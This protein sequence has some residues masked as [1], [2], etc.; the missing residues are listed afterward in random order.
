M[1]RTAVAA[2][3]LA[4]AASTGTAFAQDTTDYRVL[5]TNKTSTMQK[6]MNEAADAGFRFGG[7]MGGE[8]SFGGSEVVIIMS[9]SAASG[10]YDYRLLAT[11]KTSTMQKEMQEAGDAGFEYKGQSIFKSA[12][13]GKEVVVILERDKDVK[14]AA[15]FEYRLL[16]TKKTSTLQ[17]ELAEAG[18]AGYQFV[19]MTVADTLVGGTEVVAILRR[20]LK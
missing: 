5:A 10:R 11:N 19:G 15:P 3:V 14:S 17:K 9:K 7:V 4:L 16:A 2:C 12:F 1:T 13:G 18:E 6:E 20:K 8:T